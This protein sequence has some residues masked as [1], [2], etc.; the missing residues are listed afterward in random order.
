VFYAEKKTVEPYRIRWGNRSY[1]VK[2]VVTK[3]PVKSGETRELHFS[4]E[5]DSRDIAELALLIEGAALQWKLI[6]IHFAGT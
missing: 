2:K 6:Y 5:L 4:V 1:Q 3:W